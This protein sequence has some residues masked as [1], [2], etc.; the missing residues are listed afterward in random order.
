[1]SYRF[2]PTLSYTF[3]CDREC[4]CDIDDK[5]YMEYKHR[6]NRT[7]RV[8]VYKEFCVEMDLFSDTQPYPDWVFDFREQHLSKVSSKLI[9]FCRK[10]KA[11]NVEFKIRA[12]CSNLIKIYKSFHNK[13]W[14]FRFLCVSLRCN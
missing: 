4:G 9:K 14:L 1:M 10:L 5:A 12:V 6:I 2:A 7:N 13:I 3:V 11:A 8:S